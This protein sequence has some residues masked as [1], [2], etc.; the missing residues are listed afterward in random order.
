MDRCRVASANRWQSL[1]AWHGKRV[2]LQMCYN[3]CQSQQIYLWSYILCC[4][5]L[6]M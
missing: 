3:V 1:S 2:V 4:V 5:W 6:S